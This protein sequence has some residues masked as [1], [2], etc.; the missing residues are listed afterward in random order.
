MKKK[1]SVKL[2]V[3]ALIVLLLFQNCSIYRAKEATVDEATSFPGKVKIK[4]TSKETFKF[5]RLMK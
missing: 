5:E 4:T 1:L 2:F 3:G